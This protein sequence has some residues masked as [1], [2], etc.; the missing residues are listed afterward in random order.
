LGAVAVRMMINEDK[1]MYLESISGK[2]PIYLKSTLNGKYSSSLIDMVVNLL[3][4]IPKE[5]KSLD[6]VLQILSYLN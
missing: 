6:E 4:P 3:S 5:R 1:V 2:L